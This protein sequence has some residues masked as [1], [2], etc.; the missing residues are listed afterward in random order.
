MYWVWELSIQP[1]RLWICH[2]MRRLLRKHIPG[3]DRSFRYLKLHFLSSIIRLWTCHP[4][5]SLLTN[6]GNIHLAPT[7]VSAISSCISLAPFMPIS[8]SYPLIGLQVHLVG[9]SC[10][11]YILNFKFKRNFILYITLMCLWKKCS[12]RKNILY[13]TL[14]PLEKIIIICT[15]QFLFKTNQQ[16]NTEVHFLCGAKF[17]QKF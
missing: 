10:S 11:N 12:T 2:P 3:S 7:E 9:E 4:I 14:T 13:A 16:E 15:V 5:R 17:I 1:I 8:S 6:L